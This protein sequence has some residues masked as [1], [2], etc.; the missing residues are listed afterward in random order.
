MTK[1][2]TLISEA[3]KEGKYRIFRDFCEAE[4]IEF[5]QSITE[6]SLIKFS[7]VKGIGKIRFNAVIERLEELDIY[8]N[9][10]KD[11]LAFD[12][13]SLKEGNER[14]LK[15]ARI[16]EIFTGSSF[17]IL[18]L[19]CKN[20]GIESLLDLTNKDIKEFR[21]E[22]GIG[23]KRY[24][25]FIERLS[26]AVDEL[27]SKDNDFFSDP[28][29]EITKEAYESYKDTK[30]STLAKVF[31]LTYLDLDLYIRDIQGKN[32]SEILDLKIEDELDELNILAIKL[33]M[34]RTI[35]DIIDIILNNLNDQEAVAIIARFIENLSLQETAY[36]LEVSREQA[37]KVEMIALEKIQNL[38]HIYNGIES[39]KIMFDGADEL[40]IGD[41]ERALGE[42]GEFIINLIKDNKL[43][44][45][46]Y[47]EVCA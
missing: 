23:D 2:N 5:V 41:L 24:A 25:D 21:K 31:N 1:V 18:R 42:K 3:F 11:K 8:I 10:F 32:Y 28:K 35:E 36:I 30:L 37:R 45:I 34:T 7:K 13:D 47:T 4:D 14:V 33:N 20:R 12:I 6:E 16:K 43:N 9:P 38:F 17:R 29:F 27:I 46:A 26:A 40:S 39:L 44:G 22:K 15:E 19:Y